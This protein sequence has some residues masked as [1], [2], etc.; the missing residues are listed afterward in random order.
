VRQQGET[1]VQWQTK[2]G[3]IMNI[4]EFQSYYTIQKLFYY[5]NNK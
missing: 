2:R 1:K 5:N 4:I 3:I